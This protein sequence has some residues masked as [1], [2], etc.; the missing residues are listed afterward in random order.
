MTL[1]KYPEVLTTIGLYCK[2]CDIAIT[3]TFRGQQLLN[4]CQTECGSLIYEEELLLTPREEYEIKLY[5]AGDEALS[6]LPRVLDYLHTTLSIITPPGSEF[7]NEH[8]SHGLG[9][10]ELHVD[11][12]VWC[13]PASFKLLGYEP[14]EISTD[15]LRPRATMHPDDL[16]VLLRQ[17]KLVQSGKFNDISFTGRQRHKNGSW[18]WINFMGNV[19]ERDR[20]GKPVRLSGLAVDIT[21]SV[22]TQRRLED[23]QVVLLSLLNN[24]PDIIIFK[25]D[26][27]RYSMVNKA[28]E[29]Q[30]GLQFSE[31]DGKTDFEVFARP[32]AERM[33]QLDEQIIAGRKVFR[34]QHSPERSSQ[35]FRVVDSLKT[36][37][38]GT[39]DRFL[40]LLTVNRDITEMKRAEDELLKAK[41][42]SERA[43]RTKTDFITNISHEIRTP[44]NGFMG[45]TKLTLMTPLSDRQK[46]YLEMAV[47]AGQ[48]LMKLVEDI[49]AYAS[50][51]KGVLRL[52]AD[53]FSMQD[54]LQRLIIRYEQEAKR[55][56]L[57]FTC[58]VP[59]TLPDGVYGDMDRLEHLLE[60]ILQNAVKFTRQGEVELT[61]ACS[62]SEFG[63]F[64]L[65][66]FTV[67][68]TGIGIARENQETIFE[69]FNQADNSLTRKYG[70]TGLG[71]TLSRYLA[72]LMN[73]G[74]KVKSELHK[75]STFTVWVNLGEVQSPGLP[76]LPV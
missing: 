17:L 4:T 76:P 46:H 61:A 13:S 63:G 24:T 1:A 64:K 44:L 26:E 36:P 72:R 45:L 27:L 23:K 48:Q 52:H 51:E 7:A 8:Y 30:Y 43:N 49:L 37:L 9:I 62:D 28:F 73:G 58:N 66:M 57:Q 75:G 70:G 11:G 41:D 69:G 21:K 34:H 35:H 65:W 16:A 15:D 25:D 53:N 32:V 59:E 22:E 18:V 10:W 33:R 5:M 71:L 19:V 68:D 31:I 39:D 40:G 20:Y 54:L 42:L 47:E 74:I 6:S 56:N 60:N 67:R 3:I 29:E 14:G 55:K 12:K 38:F 50:I 2:H